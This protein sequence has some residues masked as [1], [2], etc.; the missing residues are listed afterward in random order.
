[1][2]ISWGNAG[3]EC[4]EIVSQRLKLCREKRVIKD[5]S[6]VIFDHAQTFTGSV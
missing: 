6:H 3:R 1:M 5:E 4:A 2:S